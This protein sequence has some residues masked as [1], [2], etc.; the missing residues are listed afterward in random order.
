MFSL[1]AAILAGFLAT[2]LMTV[3]MYSGKIMGLSMDMPRAIGLT[4]VG[5]DSR[6]L[7]VVG[8]LAHFIMGCL[9]AIVYALIFWVVDA[10]SS[11]GAL[12]AW[13]VLLGALHGLGVGMIMGVLPQLHP[14]TGPGMAIEPPGYFGSNYGMAMPLGMMVMH[15]IFGGVLAVVYGLLIL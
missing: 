2:A 7:Y 11:F 9:F 14:R 10:T 3:S 12:A 13:G 6:G 8:L 5:E 15:L 4:F 1:S